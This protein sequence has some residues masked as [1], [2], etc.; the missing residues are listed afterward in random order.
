MRLLLSWSWRTSRELRSS[1]LCKRLPDLPVIAISSE[2]LYL[3]YTATLGGAA[4]LQK[5]L[6]ISGLGDAAEAQLAS[7][8]L[9]VSGSGALGDAA[10]H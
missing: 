5:P 7:S 10:W 3:D 4:V 8:N 2:A 6:D 9:S 1:A